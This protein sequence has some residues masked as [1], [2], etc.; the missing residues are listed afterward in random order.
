MPNAFCRLLDIAIPIAQAGMGGA[1]SPELVAAVSNA[2]GLGLIGLS[3]S[4]FDDLELARQ[5]VR[6]TRALTPRPFGA[7]IILEWEPSGRLDI[8]LDE[9]VRL[10][11]F[12]FGDP[13]PYVTR[14]HDAGALVSIMVGTPA[15][16]KSAVDA[17][18]D[19]IIAQGWEA[20][21][22]PAGQIATMALVPAVVDAVGGQVPVLAAGGIADGRGLAAAIALGASGA[23][24]GTR[25]LASR[26][27]AI[28]PEYQQRILTAG[29][30]DTVYTKVFNGGWD[31]AQRVLRNSTYARWDAA[32]QPP[33]G[34]RPD[35]GEIVATSF[36][37]GD[38]ARYQ[39]VVAGPE[40]E[41]DIEALPLWA[42]QG[43][44]LA[45]ELM[46]AGEIV[47]EIWKEAKDAQRRLSAAIDGSNSS[48]PIDP[49]RN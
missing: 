18:V 27:A 43:V 34:L 3:V 29:V 2:G 21:G 4:Y 33:D 10:I 20:G 40:C 15:E 44:G 45:K 7:N 37:R 32:G 8:C 36:R 49:E 1:T 39:C 38:I 31:A 12:S 19:L 47:D 26:E 25:F 22:H 24:I 46:T 9:G 30:A 5:E 35:E 13:A 28:H 41:G 6:R 42:G 14:I 48:S 16:A 11:S 23:Y 17:G